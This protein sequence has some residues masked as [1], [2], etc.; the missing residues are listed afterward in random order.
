MRDV[1]RETMSVH[2][3]YSPYVLPLVF[4]SIPD[5]RLVV[6]GTPVLIYGFSVGHIVPKKSDKEQD[7][8]P[9]TPDLAAGILETGS[10]PD[11]LTFRQN[12]Q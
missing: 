7:R 3:C 9:L 10:L 5:V 1:L 4:F 2:H 8:T 11:G 6:E 12:K